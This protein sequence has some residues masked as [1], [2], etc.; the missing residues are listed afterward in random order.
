VGITRPALE[1]KSSGAP[2]E[3]IERKDAPIATGLSDVTVT[4]DEGE[5]TAIVSITGIEDDVKDIILPGAYTETLT[6]RRP[7]G[8]WSHAWEHP[9]ARVPEAVELPPGDPRLPAETKDGKPWPKEAG[10]L[11]TRLQFNLK[12]QAGRDAFESVK[13]FSESGECEWSIG[14]RVPRGGAVKR[15]DGVREIKKLELY[16]VSPVLFGAAPQTS[17]LSLKS[18][19]AAMNELRGTP[20]SPIETKEQPPPEEKGK[21]EDDPGELTEE[22]LSGMFEA[23]SD[24]IDKELAEQKPPA[25]PEDIPQGDEEEREGAT[26]DDPTAAT[27]EG[28][29]G[30]EGAPDGG[31]EAPVG[32]GAKTA[33]PPAMETKDFSDRPWGN[34]TASDYSPEQ[35]HAACLIHLHDA[36]TP[37]SKGDCKLPVKEPGGAYSKAGIHAAAAAL[38]GARG[39]LAAPRAMK[40]A[41]AKRLIGLYRK[42][43]EDPPD[44]LTNLAGGGQKDAQLR[45]VMADAP[46]GEEKAAGVDTHPAAAE[47]LRQYWEHGEGAA[48]INWGVPGDYN[49]CVRLLSKYLGQRAHGYCQLRH[50]GA[51]GAY[52]GHA[53]GEGKGLAH[54]PVAAALVDELMARVELKMHDDSSSSPSRSSS[55]GTVAT[56]N[57]PAGAFNSGAHP[58]DALGKFSVSGSGGGGG[59][60]GK[61]KGK[62]KGSQG[63]QRRAAQLTQRA[64]QVAATVKEQQA[65]Q[66]RRAAFDE[67]LKQEKA[68]ETQRQQ[69]AADAIQKARD[70]GDTTQASQMQQQETARH[71][72]W[73]QGITD[74]QAAEQQRRTDW[75]N[76]QKRQQ[77]TAQVAS[78]QQAAATAQAAAGKK[79]VGE[80]MDTEVTETKDAPYLAGSYEERTNALTDAIRAAV[81]GE[82]GQQPMSLE[83]QEGDEAEGAGTSVN[84]DNF[85]VSIE[86]TYDDHV[87]ATIYTMDKGER[88]SYLFPYTYDLGSGVVQVGDPQPVT[89]TVVVESGDKDE[90][91]ESP[92][93]AEGQQPT[94][95]APAEPNAATGVESS[96]NA[97][98]QQAKL[99]SRYMEAVENKAGRMLSTRN[100]QQLRSALQGLISVLAAAGVDIGSL[101]APSVGG[102]GGGEPEVPE[103]KEA[104]AEDMVRLSE[105]EVVS[106]TYGL[107]ADSRS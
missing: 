24:D 81:L 68:A 44:S 88:D 18:A 99:L 62:G 50:K 2:P 53:P 52:A 70:N 21:E 54:N 96:I 84:P 105:A 6:K 4:G 29:E 5:V 8:V 57:A 22:Q 91:Q 69:A 73:Q 78:A 86:G 14:Y 7:K 37:D 83:P 72:K 40:V 1:F 19:V 101:V 100:A 102:V 61:G 107:F 85:W 75:S 16:E 43:G 104:P 46:A 26:D 49:R 35:W 23:A 74:A 11:M 66:D 38:A 33:D 47:K 97:A 34:Y 60:G 36:G 51:T 55:A 10:G 80:A 41:A 94:G 42:M 15:K 27:P 76:A 31:A 48:K 39:G 30:H 64:N 28:A 103:G 67:H 58:R 63:A 56:G 25:A 45:L 77:Q 82:N 89:L 79:D 92:P 93:A 17:T 32:D 95:A 65:E 106:A 12:T 71:A 59:K 9:I 87:I 20:D 98:T 90:A 13:F 3:G